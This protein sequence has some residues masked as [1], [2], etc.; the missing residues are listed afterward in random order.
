MKMSGGNNKNYKNTVRTFKY[1]NNTT[2]ITEKYS[3]LKP[4]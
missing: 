4:G 3:F 1:R 2:Q